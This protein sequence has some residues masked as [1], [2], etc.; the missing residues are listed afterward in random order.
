MG[1][2][3]N[4]SKNK[5][6]VEGCNLFIEFNKK[7]KLEY[8]GKG[9]YGKTYSFINCEGKYRILKIIDITNSNTPGL[10]KHY[11]Y[12]EREGARSLKDKCENNINYYHFYEEKGSFF[13]GFEMEFANGGVCELIFFLN[14]NRTLNI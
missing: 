1:L 6:P 14:L 13:V 4:M 9:A 11:A 8:K 2:G 5:D 7:Y 3:L 10:L 12:G